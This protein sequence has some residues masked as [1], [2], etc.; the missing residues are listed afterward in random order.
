M[1]DGQCISQAALF[2]GHGFYVTA[3]SDNSIKEAARG[4]RSYQDGVLE[5]ILSTVD[6]VVPILFA[7]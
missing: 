5:S 2:F 1:E 6:C 4:L 3:S 7:H